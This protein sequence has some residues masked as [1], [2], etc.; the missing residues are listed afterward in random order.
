MEPMATTASWPDLLEGEELAHVE[1]VP[2]REARFA[3]LPEELHPRVRDALAAQGIESLYGHQA[4]AW[5]AAARGEHF[6]VTTGTASGKTLAF[7]LPILDALAREPKRR[8][9]Y[10]YPTKALAQDQLRSLGSFRPPRMPAPIHDRD[11]AAAGATCSRTSPRWSSTRRTSTAGS[12]ARTSA[13]S[14][15]GFGDSLA[16]TE[17]SR[18]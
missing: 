11:T 13:T 7:N 8:A 16:S 9:L 17:R 6:V 3:P 14:C 2:A 1:L 12:S 18:S 5:A 15:G 10:L 4:E